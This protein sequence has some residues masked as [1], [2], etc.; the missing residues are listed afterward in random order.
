ML[1]DI[2][3]LSVGILFQNR[4]RIVR[5]IKG[6]PP[7]AVYDVVDEKTN[8]CCLLEVAASD[9]MSID[10]IGVHSEIESR[11]GG[12]F[13][14][15]PSINIFE[16]GIEEDT[17]QSFFALESVS[18]ETPTTKFEVS[19]GFD[20]DIPIYVEESIPAPAVSVPIQ[21]PPIPPTVA[22]RPM[23][24]PPPPL[25]EKSPPRL[26]PPPN[27]PPRFTSTNGEVALVEVPR[28]L[29]ANEV[30]ASY[31]PRYESPFRG[32]VEPLVVAEAQV[33]VPQSSS[34]GHSLRE[35]F[36]RHRGVIITLAIGFGLV[37]LGLL[38][39]WTQ[40]KQ[41]AVKDDSIRI[42]HAPEAKTSE[43]V[44]PAPISNSARETR[45]PLNMGTTATGPQRTTRDTS[46]KTT[47]KAVRG[48]VRNPPTER[49]TKI[50]RESL[51]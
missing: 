35:P 10:D 23:L 39:L 22:T 18:D 34:S 51:F 8:A 13:D 16:P 45:S 36:R 25:L 15:E 2:D 11:T 27:P 19:D 17:M 5:C 31:P 9:S 43:N 50:A 4:Y 20:I 49:K 48:P 40:R 41:D 26:L 47:D 1:Q 28:L 32:R 12:I 37:A 6:G 46:T 30:I 42:G 21:L 33:E 7:S 24:P 29:P 14:R 3:P 38:S 44:A